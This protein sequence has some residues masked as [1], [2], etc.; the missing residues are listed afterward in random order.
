[1]KEVKQ[2]VFNLSGYGAIGPVGPDGF[3]IYF[4]ELCVVKDD[5]FAFLEEVHTRG[6]LFKDMSAFIIC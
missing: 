3:L 6:N 5:V 4:F 1:M 2:V